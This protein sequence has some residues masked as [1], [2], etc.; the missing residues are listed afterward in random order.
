MPRH[1]GRRLALTGAVL[2]LSISGSAWAA[3]QALPGGGVQVN[4]DPAVGINPARDAG[5]SDVTGGALLAGKP[6]VP[7]ATFE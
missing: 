6:G 7:W 4:D 3:F 5:L 1:R 2:T